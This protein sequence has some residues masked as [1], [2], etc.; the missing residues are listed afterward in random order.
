MKWI[1]MAVAQRPW[2]NRTENGTKGGEGMAAQRLYAAIDLK[3]FYAS[4]ECVERGL[5]PLEARLV[6][7]DETRTDKTICLAV[8]PALK[9]FGLA[10][11][12]R[13]FEVHQR[14]ADIKASTGREVDF[15][16]A[17]PRMQLY[18]EYSARIDE[19]YTQFVSREDMHVYSVDEVFLDLTGYL[20]LYR[21]T[22]EELTRRMVREVFRRTGITATAGIGTNLY[23]AKI[24]MD[25]VA[26]HAEP[27]ET[28]VRM[29]FLDEMRYREQLW[30]HRPL[31]DFWR[32]GH[33]IAGRL[34]R[35]GM[36]TMGDVA[37]MSLH[38]EALLHREFGVD[39]ELLIDHAWGQESCTMADIHAFRPESSSRSEGQIL[40]CAYTWEKA[41]IVTREMAE[42]LALSLLA[43]GEVCEGVSLYVSYDGLSTAVAGATERDYYGRTR[44]KH[45]HGGAWLTDAGGARCPTN[46]ARKIM[47]T[48]LALYDRLVDPRLMVRRIDI[49]CANV[50]P[51][52]AAEPPARQLDFF[53]DEEALSREREREAHEERVQLAMLKMKHRFG[54]N[55][56]LRGTSLEEGATAME[57]N[58]Q[59]GGHRSGVK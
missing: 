47:E 21:C 31:T 51:Q 48:V 24:A 38:D 37:R 36:R 22:A 50:A 5:D 20:A 57:R 12:C 59:I 25:I 3:S 40:P 13:L 15:I 56:V 34:E 28:G 46:S 11:R 35:H 27:D 2:Y 43:A 33:G 18:M 8:S 4:V 9:A 53:T 17:P 39:A 1:D 19:I 23:L 41:R 6:V 26:K 58:R 52:G 10:G 54:A 7:A 44:P 45:A 29:A 30:E 14:L 49:G 42:K 16:I 32:I 55:A